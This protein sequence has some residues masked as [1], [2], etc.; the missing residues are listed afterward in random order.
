MCNMAICVS[1]STC[2]IRLIYSM[3]GYSQGRATFTIGGRIQE[4]LQYLY[5]STEMQ[6]RSEPKKHQENHRSSRLYQS[7]ARTLI[8]PLLRAAGNI[9]LLHKRS[10]IFFFLRVRSSP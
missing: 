9:K 6:P 5:P 1:V 10:L 7:P 2:G 3:K 4:E 8:L